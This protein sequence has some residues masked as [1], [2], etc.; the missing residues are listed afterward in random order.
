MRGSH[1][2]PSPRWYTEVGAGLLQTMIIQLI[3]RVALSYVAP[4]V[5]SLKK[6]LMLGGVKSLEAAQILVTGPDLALPGRLGKLYAFAAICLLFSTGMPLMFALLAVYTFCCYYIDKWSV[7]RVCQTPIPYSFKIIAATIWWVKYILVA[8]LAFAW[9]AFGSLPG[10]PLSAALSAASDL[11]ES[12]GADSTVT[13]GG[14]A[15]ITT[16]GDNYPSQRLAPGGPQITG[17]GEAL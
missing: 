5:F 14:D 11:A 7:L 13:Q 12:A 8:K 6:S 10:I 9:W 1:F 3:V 15:L 2:D 16:L 4:L 17:I